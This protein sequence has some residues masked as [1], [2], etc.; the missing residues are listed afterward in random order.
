MSQ[1]YCTNNQLKPEYG[2]SFCEYSVLISR[3]LA[4]Y[5]NQIYNG[6]FLP[7]NFSFYPTGN[8]LQVS[9]D[10]SE[11]DA[12]DNSAQIPTN[13]PVLMANPAA[14]NC[15]ISQQQPLVLSSNAASE[16]FNGKFWR[17]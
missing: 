9:N 3:L 7:G 4:L 5:D 14:A 1:F 15:D 12:T 17:F 8:Q 6:L 13:F 10:E 2:K 11:T 16:M